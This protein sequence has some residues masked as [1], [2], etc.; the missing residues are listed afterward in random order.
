LKI[1]T[2][3]ATIKDKVMKEQDT[4]SVYLSSYLPNLDYAEDEMFDSGLFFMQDY[5]EAQDQLKPV[6]KELTD[7][8]LQT[9]NNTKKNTTERN[10][11]KNSMY[12]L[13]HF[14]EPFSSDIGF[15]IEKII[16]NILKL[17]KT[18]FD[19]ILA[20]LIDNEKEITLKLK[21]ISLGSNDDD[22]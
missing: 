7:E 15:I 22:D 2:K 18:F 10:Y 5:L 21:E 16:P 4:Q 12:G 9:I 3:Q 20:K 6:S 19:D 1:F 13:I 11:S 17:M 8:F 14:Y